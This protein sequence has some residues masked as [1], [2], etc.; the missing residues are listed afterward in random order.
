MVNSGALRRS[1]NALFSLARKILNITQCD[2]FIN[3]RD[4]VFCNHGYNYSSRMEP[5][6]QGRFGFNVQV[7]EDFS[8]NLAIT[9]LVFKVSRRILRP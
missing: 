3:F 1:Q 5:D 7:I 6:E 4:D 9:M 2:V 8:R